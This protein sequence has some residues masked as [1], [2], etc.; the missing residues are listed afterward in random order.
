M[1]SFKKFLLESLSPPQ[2][3]NVLPEMDP[4][5]PGI[6]PNQWNN[7]A[8]NIRRPIARD[9]DGEPIDLNDIDD[10]GQP[11]DL[12]LDDDN[13]GI[14]D[15][16]DLD[17]DADNIP[18]WMDP[19]WLAANGYTPQDIQNLE[20][21]D[22]DGI[23]DD[24]DDDHDNDGVPNSRDKEYLDMLR[25][26]LVPDALQRMQEEPPPG[27]QRPNRQNNNQVG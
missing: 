24:F 18:D 15:E 22:G 11:N 1:F 3:A 17:D 23:P 16:Y 2:P 10:D 5:F 21:T 19:D 27:Q 8:S 9:E 25:G 6:N 12:D 7:P 4:Q 14:A 20:D 13:D 26:R